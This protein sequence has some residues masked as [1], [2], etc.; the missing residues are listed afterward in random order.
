MAKQTK[1]TAQ[2]RP[3]TGR[4]AVKKIKAQ[5]L[6]PAVIYARGEEPLP[7]QVELR[8]MEN[9]LSHAVGEQLLVELAIEGAKGSRLALIQ[10]IQ[11]HPVSQA[12]LHV[13]FQGVRADEEIEANIPVEATG[14][15]AGVKTG[16][17][18][19]EQ[20]AR[21]I[22]IRCLPKDLPG[23]ITVDIAALQIGDTLKVK[24]IA[25]PAG[26]KAVDPEA[27]IFLVAE[28]T[29]IAEEPAAAAAAAPTEP[30]MIKE[31]KPAEGA[32]APAEKAEK[33]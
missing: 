11:H 33:K 10:E 9:L 16:G 29:V 23:V 2:K 15:A 20:L 7:L 28:P 5:G 25:L 30:E 26:V 21:T 22:A 6:V 31:K 8:A 1:L 4:P 27:T 18:L 17:G 14:E 19:L 32:P 3:E 24:A 12:I 13:D